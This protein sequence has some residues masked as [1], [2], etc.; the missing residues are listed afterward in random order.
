M[1]IPFRVLLAAVGAIVVFVII[2]RFRPHAC[3]DVDRPEERRV[4]KVSFGS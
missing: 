2:Y 3:L 4:P 1:G